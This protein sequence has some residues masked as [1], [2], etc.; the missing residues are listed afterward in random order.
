M[1][2]MIRVNCPLISSALSLSVAKNVSHHELFSAIVF[3]ATKFHPGRKQRKK[4]AVG[5]PTT[6]KSKEV[7]TR[8][9]W[10]TQKKK[11]FLVTVNSVRV[12]TLLVVGENKTFWSEFWKL[13]SATT[14]M[15]SILPSK[16]IKPHTPCRQDNLIYRQFYLWHEMHL[17]RRYVLKIRDKCIFSGTK[18]VFSKAVRQIMLND[19]SHQSCSDIVFIPQR[20]SIPS[21][22]QENT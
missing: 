12:A 19:G 5:H 15:H 9:N 4:V 18:A 10:R 7:P 3:I 13:W 11:F 16:Y 1:W 8:N 20:N 17:S 21:R 14:K 6:R 22:E 2:I